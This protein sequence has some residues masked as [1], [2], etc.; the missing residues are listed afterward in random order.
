[1]SAAGD[2]RR[3]AGSGSRS[4]FFQR[5]VLGAAAGQREVRLIL[6]LGGVLGG[7]HL[8]VGSASDLARLMGISDW[9]IG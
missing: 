6:G 7:A 5:A 2:A 4:P 9:A 3:V 1:M 8:L